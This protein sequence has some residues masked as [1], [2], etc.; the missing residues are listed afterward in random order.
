MET[1]KRKLEVKKGDPGILGVTALA[2]GFNFSIVLP[3]GESGSLLLYRKGS[4]RVSR[5]FQLTEDF[6][7]GDVAALWIGGI[8]PDQ[9]E[10]NYRIGGRVITDPYARRIVGRERFGREEK[11]D[12]E[13]QVRGRIVDMDSWED[14][15]IFIPYQEA[16]FY[17]VHVRG[18]TQRKSS[19][20]VHRGTFRGL[21]EKI[22]YIKSLGVT[23]WN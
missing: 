9:Y 12:R 2:G 1:E 21:Q 20:A 8:S 6:R 22:P 7:T 13:H 19:G 17:K 4:S 3:Q 14:K 5:E 15:S 23:P 18:Y 11:P 10:Y 16:V